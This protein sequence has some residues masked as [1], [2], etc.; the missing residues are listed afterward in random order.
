MRIKT[1]QRAT[2]AGNSCLPEFYST[3][4]LTSMFNSIFIYTFPTD[5]IQLDLKLATRR[6]LPHCYPH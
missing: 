3:L 4:T 5:Q 6:Y 1:S 2:M